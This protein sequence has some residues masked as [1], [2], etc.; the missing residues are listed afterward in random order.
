M[1]PHV[2]LGVII[3]AGASGWLI[4]EGIVRLWAWLTA[5]APTNR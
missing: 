3:V 1:T 4:P 5:D 2:W